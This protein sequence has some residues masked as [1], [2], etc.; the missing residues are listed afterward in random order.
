MLESNIARKAVYSFYTHSCKMVIHESRGT[1]R[2]SGKP[3][4]QLRHA[5]CLTQRDSQETEVSGEDRFTGSSEIT[6]EGQRQARGSSLNP[7][8]S[9]IEHPLS[10]FKMEVR[11]SRGHLSCQ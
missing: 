1:Q 4:G 6:Q 11:S 8:L 5:V 10:A 3:S 9:T 7:L 2:R